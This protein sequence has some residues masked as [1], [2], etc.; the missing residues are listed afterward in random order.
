[1]TAVSNL[2]YKNLT[3]LWW[4]ILSQDQDLSETEDPELEDMDKEIDAKSQKDMMKAIA[5]DEK[6]G[7][8]NIDDSTK[9]Y[10]QVW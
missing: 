8:E 4:S 5:E 2:I 6:E 7:S 1:M 9:A 10:I 3:L